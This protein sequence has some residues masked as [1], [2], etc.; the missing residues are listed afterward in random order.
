MERFEQGCWSIEFDK[1]ATREV[2]ERILQAGPEGCKCAYCRNFVVCRPEVYPSIFLRFLDSLGI[3]S[4]KESEVYQF[5]RM[6]DGR[7]MYGG[8][9]HFIGRLLS[10]G[11]ADEP[12][13]VAGDFECR[14]IEGSELADRLFDD[15]PLVQVVFTAY[16]PWKLS[17][18][19]PKEC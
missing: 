16:L 6:K 9:F 19:E 15:K 8:C 18:E 14:L 13:M 5:T 1:A 11:N 12:F 3:D 10:A 2:F 4:S 7:H 17:E